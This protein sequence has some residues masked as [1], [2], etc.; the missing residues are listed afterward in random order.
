MLCYGCMPCHARPWCML[1]HAMVHAM[2]CYAL[3]HAMLWWLA[4]VNPSAGPVTQCFH[5]RFAPYS[6]ARM[7]PHARSCHERGTHA[8]FPNRVF[9]KYCA[10]VLDSLLSLRKKPEVPCSPRLLLHA[11]RKGT[12]YTV[13]HEHQ[14]TSQGFP[15]N[16]LSL[17][18]S[19][20]S[21]WPCR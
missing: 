3:C 2:P 15:Y 7:T 4:G 14:G 5:P 10:Y 1:C 6:K 9:H 12:T 20:M 16:V 19:L 21:T 13:T 17:C 18:T 11:D 8:T